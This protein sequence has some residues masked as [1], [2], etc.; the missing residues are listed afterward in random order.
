MWELQ[1]YVFGTRRDTG[2]T[3]NHSSAVRFIAGRVLDNRWIKLGQ[4]MFLV[5]L[6]LAPKS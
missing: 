6:F 2:K 4:E 5:L 1:I 3:L